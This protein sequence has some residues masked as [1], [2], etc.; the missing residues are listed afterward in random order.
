MKNLSKEQVMNLE[1]DDLLKYIN[2]MLADGYSLERLN[3]EKG[4]RRQT[5]RDRLKKHGYIYDKNTNSYIKASEVNTEPQNKPQEKRKQNSEQITLEKVLER[6]ESL[7]MRLNSI[8]EKSN[9]DKINN[10]EMKRFRSEQQ[11]RNYPLHME[12]VELL[13]KISKD[14]PHFTI[15]EIVNNALYYGLQQMLDGETQ[16]QYR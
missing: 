2:Q 15:K 3:K 12:V 8:E 7:E 14:N 6:L 4:I 11:A 1:V 5:I 13:A 9:Q 16:K 10:F